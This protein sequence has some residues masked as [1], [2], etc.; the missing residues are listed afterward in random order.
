[1]DGKAG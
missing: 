1:M